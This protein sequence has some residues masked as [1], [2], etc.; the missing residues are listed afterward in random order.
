MAMKTLFY[1]LLTTLVIFL[2]CSFSSY[3]QEEKREILIVINEK[4]PL[5]SKM[6]LAE[7]KNI[8][9]GMVKSEKKIKLSPVDQKDSEIFKEF[10]TRFIGL[11]PTAYKGHWV[12]KL[13]EDGSV[14]P[15]VASTP[16]DVLKRVS[17]SAGGIGYIWKED[18]INDENIIVILVL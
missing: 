11:T 9:L 1:R 3:A 15:S 13:F 14:A 4:S 5:P 2:I 10:L 6:S 17:G 16:E 8:Y 7:I 18:L 12:K